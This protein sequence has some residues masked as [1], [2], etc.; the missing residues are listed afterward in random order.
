M[1]PRLAFS[2]VSPVDSEQLNQ[3]KDNDRKNVSADIC[4]TT[5][6][7]L[8]CPTEEITSETPSTCKETSAPQPHMKTTCCRTSPHRQFVVKTTFETTT[9]RP[10][11]VKLDQ[12]N[13][14]N[15]GL[16]VV[17]LEYSGKKKLLPLSDP[18]FINLG[19]VGQFG[20]ADE[21]NATVISGQEALDLL[22]FARSN[23]SEEP[24]VLHED[25][26]N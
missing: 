17:P 12:L 19:N 10:V 22:E 5:E 14:N 9:I 13:I 20:I 26:H 24:I 1:N 4:V 18:E 23:A 8:V 21:L 11:A 2:A 25:M 6:V 3:D 15:F 16:T 7:P